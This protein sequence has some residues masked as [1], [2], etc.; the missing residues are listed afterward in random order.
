MNASQHP[1]TPT[2]VAIARDAS[3]GHITIQCADAPAD[4]ILVDGGYATVWS[5]HGFRLDPTL[6]EALAGAL[7]AF[8]VVHQDATP[9][10]AH[11]SRTSSAAAN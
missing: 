10:H 2:A 4:R 11:A 3:T 6:A 1:T 7:H 9:G 8:A 5:G